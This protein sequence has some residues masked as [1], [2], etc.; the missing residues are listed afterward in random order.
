[1]ECKKKSYMATSVLFKCP[2]QQLPS[3]YTVVVFS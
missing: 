3:T 2:H 1:M